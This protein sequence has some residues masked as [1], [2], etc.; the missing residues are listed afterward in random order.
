MQSSAHKR[1]FFENLE[2]TP[3]MRWKKIRESS[4]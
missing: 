2:Q 3:K 4:P 1:L